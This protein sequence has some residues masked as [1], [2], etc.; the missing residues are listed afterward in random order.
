MQYRR[1]YVVGIEERSLRLVTSVQEEAIRVRR[2]R[3]VNDGLHTR[4]ATITTLLGSRTIRTGAGEFVEVGVYI[5][6]MV[7]GYKQRSGSSSP[8]RR[9]ART[10]VV[11]PRRVEAT[12]RVCVPARDEIILRGHESRE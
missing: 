10:N 7:N 2:T 5:V 9:V 1:T 3:L 4:I 6:D 8:S 12:F 11:V